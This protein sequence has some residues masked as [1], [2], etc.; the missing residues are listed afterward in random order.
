MLPIRCCARFTSLDSGFDSRLQADAFLEQGLRKSLRAPNWNA[1]VAPQFANL[2]PWRTQLA[3]SHVRDIEDMATVLAGVFG[4]PVGS[5]RTATD[6]RRG[7]HR[8]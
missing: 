5:A 2:M 3:N 4:H 7:G 8:T 6:N 1:H